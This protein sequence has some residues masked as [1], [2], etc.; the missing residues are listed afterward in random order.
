M[1]FI[2][3][4][5]QI[6]IT[7]VIP[8]LIIGKIY[9]KS[10]MVKRIVIFPFFIL[11]W[12]LRAWW[13]VYFYHEEVGDPLSWFCDLCV[14]VLPMIAG[15][16]APKLCNKIEVLKEGKKYFE[17]QQTNLKSK[18]KKIPLAKELDLNDKI[19]MA[20]YYI[21]REPFDAELAEE[22][23]K[24]GMSPAQ[25]QRA[26]QLFVESHDLKNSGGSD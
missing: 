22:A 10:G 11:N 25:F 19:A 6:I 12:G 3:I 13:A 4:F 26:C 2:N 23:E 18:E 20:V 1:A 15:A 8:L 9:K 7:I 17:E 5:L 21:N 16:I 24:I 14:F